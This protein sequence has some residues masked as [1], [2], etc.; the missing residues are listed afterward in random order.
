MA[1]H[2]PLGCMASSK[3]VSFPPWRKPSSYPA[4]VGSRAYCALISWLK[5][6]GSCQFT[7]GSD[8]SSSRI[9]SS[10]A[11]KCGATEDRASLVHSGKDDAPFRLSRNTSNTA[12]HEHFGVA[13]RDQHETGI[14]TTH[15][16]K[17]TD[18]GRLLIP[19]SGEAR[20]EQLLFGPARTYLWCPVRSA[21]MRRN[22][23]ICRRTAAFSVHIKR[24][25]AT[26]RSSQANTQAVM[27]P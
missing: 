11:R 1:R 21:R 5:R 13:I 3:G 19:E 25:E 23:N 20:L 14:R 10:N 16:P 12:L 7:S 2:T 17:R 15:L 24:E 6:S 27:M 22:P 26:A 18:T 4:S 8:W 9:F